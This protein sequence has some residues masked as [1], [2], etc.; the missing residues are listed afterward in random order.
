MKHEIIPVSPEL[1]ALIGTEGINALGLPKRE[2]FLLDIVVAGT[3]FCPVSTGALPDATARHG[4]TH[5][6]PAT[7]RTRRARHR[8]LLRGAPHRLRAT[9]A[10]PSHLSLDGRWQRVLRSGRPGEEDQRVGT[11]I[12]SALYDRVAKCPHQTCNCGR[13]AR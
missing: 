5:G 9:R 12:G 6:T 7:K 10:Q 1:L 2:I 4:V 8:H 13:N 3:T 11:Y